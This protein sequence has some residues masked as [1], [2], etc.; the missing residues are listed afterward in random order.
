MWKLLVIIMQMKKFE[1]FLN[2]FLQSQFPATSTEAYGGQNYD[3]LFTVN[4]TT[5]FY[6]TICTVIC[7]LPAVLTQHSLDINFKVE[8]KIIKKTLGKAHQRSWI[9]H[10]E[11]CLFIFSNNSF[12][13]WFEF[14]CH[15]NIFKVNYPCCSGV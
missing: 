6:W 1:S 5:A 8:I 10:G 7:A 3:F 15:R 2:H 12:V 4:C 9:W 13:N 14:F 11:W